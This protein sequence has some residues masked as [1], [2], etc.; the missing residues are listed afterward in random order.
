MANHEFTPQETFDYCT[1]KL[2]SHGHGR[3]NLTHEDLF[4]EMLEKGSGKGGGEKSSCR[5][6]TFIEN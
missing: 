3:K 5:P 4:L 6:E 2:V 1:V